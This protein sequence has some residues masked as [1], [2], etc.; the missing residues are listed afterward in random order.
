[1]KPV[2][3][4]A[5]LGVAVLLGGCAPLV[6]GGAATGVA[7]VHDRRPAKTVAMDQ[8]L[9]IQIKSAL[10]DEA[11]FD[12]SDVNITSYNMQV[13][14]TG[15]VPT[16]EAGLAAERIAREFNEVRTVVNEL[17]IGEPSR[18]SARSRDA[19]ITT[20][21]KTGLFAVDQ[22]GFDPTRVKVITE[23]GVVYLMG[24][25]TA[26]EAEA[27]TAQARRVRGVRKVV[28]LFEIVR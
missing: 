12:D 1:M 19:W 2:V 3:L 11:W 18:L 23:R 4:P 6:V 14:L 5:L 25:V 9:E 7:V 10:G 8:S 20:Q 27:A 22:E 24:L 28:R 21:V 13:L 16:R 15:E 17:G 26:A